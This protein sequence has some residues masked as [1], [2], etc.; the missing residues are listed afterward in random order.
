MS[1]NMDYVYIRAWCKLMNATPDVTE[2]GV[3]TAR[4]EKAPQTA[5]YKNK[6]GTWENFEGIVRGETKQQLAELVIK[7]EKRS[8]K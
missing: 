7:M 3:E 4:K 8:K 6:D 1:E 2:N 5:V